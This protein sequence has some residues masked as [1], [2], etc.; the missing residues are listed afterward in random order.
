ME[1][2]FIAIAYMLAGIYSTLRMV[3]WWAYVSESGTVLSQP[4]AAYLKDRGVA[5]FFS[6]VG[7]LTWPIWAVLYVGRRTPL[8][9]PANLEHGIPPREARKLI[10]Q[11]KLEEAERKALAP[12][13]I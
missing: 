9:K 3:G 7:G 10:A 12:L 2:A 1:I 4:D 13:D 8:V 6:V 5:W 11:R